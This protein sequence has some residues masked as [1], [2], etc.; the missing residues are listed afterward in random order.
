MPALRADPNSS[1]VSGRTSNASINSGSIPESF[2]LEKHWL[3]NSFFCTLDFFF[4]SVVH[5]QI[6]ILLLFN[7]V[8]NPSWHLLQSS[9]CYS[10]ELSGSSN[11]SPES[12]SVFLDFS[13]RINSVWISEII[14]CNYYT[15]WISHILC[16]ASLIETSPLVFIIQLMLINQE[17]MNDRGCADKT[18]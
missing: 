2:Y 15:I 6:K 7:R 10:I 8:W 4:L 17:N 14:V 18:T 3:L 1:A 12:F 13:L 16:Q 5:F 11:D 9:N